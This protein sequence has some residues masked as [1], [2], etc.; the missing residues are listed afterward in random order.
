MKTRKSVKVIGTE[1]YLN[2]STG[3]LQEMQ[4]IS[5][6]D[7]DANFHKIWLSHL[8]YAMDI[9]GNQKTRF[10]YWLLDKMDENNYILMTMRQMAIESKISLDTVSQTIKVLMESNFLIRRNIGVYQINP[11]MIFKGGK[12]KRMGVLLEYKKSNR[13]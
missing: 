9:I 13:K 12:T 6:Q 10:A 5:I 4:V 1:T 11:D 7:R 8:L 2:Q 3:E